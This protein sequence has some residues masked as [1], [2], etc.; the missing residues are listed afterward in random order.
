MHG[1][2]DSRPNS[3]APATQKAKKDSW[4]P[5]LSDRS[6]KVREC[7]VDGP[8]STSGLRLLGLGA[9][10]SSSMV[11]LLL[12]LRATQVLATGEDCPLEFCDLKGCQHSF[13][14]CGGVVVP[15]YL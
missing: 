2:S 1:A 10:M 3:T 11:N 4:P 7:S 6:P 15:V 14:P 8:T 13:S 9:N 5:M 12:R